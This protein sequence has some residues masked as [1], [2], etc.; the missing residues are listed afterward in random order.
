MSFLFHSS[1]SRWC[2]LAAKHDRQE[3][4]EPPSPWRMRNVNLWFRFESQPKGKSE[5]Y[6][7]LPEAPPGIADFHRFQR[8]NHRHTV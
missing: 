2:N 5:E 8:S 7:M 6:M 3:D 1:Q 4:N